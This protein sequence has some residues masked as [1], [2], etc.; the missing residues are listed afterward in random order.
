MLT[1]GLDWINDS[2]KDAYRVKALRARKDFRGRLFAI[3][4][5][6]QGWVLVAIIGFVT[7]CIAFFVDVTENVLFDFKEGYCTSESL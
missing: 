2:I 5:G 4:D 7:A 3:L 6:G 1:T